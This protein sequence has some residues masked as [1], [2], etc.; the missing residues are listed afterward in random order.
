MKIQRK[1]I[2]IVLALLI[3]TSMALGTISASAY[4]SGQYVGFGTV[5]SSSYRTV[6]TGLRYDNTV[7]KGYSGGNQ[8]LQ[9]LT[10]NPKTSNYVP[11]VYSQFSGYGGTTLNAAKAA[12]SAGYDVKGGVNASFFSMTGSS[13]NTYGGVVISDGRIIQGN[14][15]HGGTFELA[16]QSDG[17]ASLIW[18]RVAYSISARNGTWSAP[19]NFVN[20]CPDS[21][22]KTYTGIYYYDSACGTKTDTKTAGIE[23]VFEKINHSQLTVGGTLEGKVVAL[24]NVSSGAAIGAN[25]FVLYA[26]NSSGYAGAL[27]SLTVGEIVKVTATE[28]VDG[29]KSVMEN[30]NSAIVTYGYHVVNNGV[31]VTSSNGLGDSFNKARA[32]RTGIGVKADGTVIIVASPGRTTSYSGMTVYELGDYL[33]SQGCVMGINLDGGGSTQ[34]TVES[35]GGTLSA[36]LSSSRRVANSILVVAR[37]T[38]S[39]SDRNELN[40][41]VAKANALL[42]SEL[43]GDVA[44]LNAAVYYANGVLSSSKSM[45]GDYTKAI[46]RLNA[47]LP[48]VAKVGYKPGIYKINAASSLYASASATSGSVASPA[49]GKTL[50]VTQVSGDYGYTK[51]LNQYGWINLTSCT[52]VG[53]ASNTAATISTP[54]Y[55]YKGQ[56]VTLSWSAVNGA[57]SYSYRVIELNGEPDPG[58]TNES[59]NARVLAEGSV[60]DALSVTIP[61]SSRIDGKYIKI[62]VCVNY[63]QSSAWSTAYLTTSAL[64]FTDVAPSH[65]GYEAVN[66]CYGNGYFSGTSATTFAPNDS[67]TRAM[68]AV[69]L[70]RMAG[71]PEIDPSVVVPF[72]DINKNA[73]Y[74]DGVAWCYS[75]GIVTGVSATELAPDMSV[76]REQAACFLYRL[77][78]AMGYDT[79]VNDPGAINAFSDASSV[80][81]Y[82]MT[83]MAWAVENNIMRGSDS[84]LLPKNA[85]TR[86]QIASLLYNFDTVLKNK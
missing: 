50:T 12:E 57:S 6:G 80:G 51:Y 14:N 63:P 38:I 48:N 81:S 73:W 32:Q 68:M 77:A 5:S 46:M 54:A 65:W 44:S 78:G 35:T 33:I 21:A 24:R 40:T 59:L 10:F 66:H 72:T 42:G 23:V 18:S 74:Y 43:T 15:D 60:T 17:T 39:A 4:Y 13:C 69:V 20:I 28:T 31:N 52:Y 61:A 58:S 16:F 86:V 45:P 47:A 85:A 56:N 8:Q 2:S 82:A 67:M 53:A 76:T 34:M 22:A 83:A 26:S 19:L 75:K 62:A 25:Q 64:P 55:A 7:V 71:C 36:V 79:T 29:A 70:Y 30:C 27:R 41:L 11:L 1:L 9:T 3:I 84:M 49:A 37:P